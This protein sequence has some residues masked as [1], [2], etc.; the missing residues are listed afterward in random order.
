MGLQNATDRILTTHIGSLPRPHA[1]LDLMK[2]K[3]EGRPYDRAAY[4]A[5]IAAT[6][7]GRPPAASTS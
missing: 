2:A 1:V 6:W 3:A 7:R 5:A 4:D